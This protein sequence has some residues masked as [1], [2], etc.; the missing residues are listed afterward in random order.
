MKIRDSRL[1]KHVF[2]AATLVA[3]TL[4]LVPPA[5]SQSAVTIISPSKQSP[6]QT[7]LVSDIPGLAVTTDPNLI[8]P[9]GIS[10]SPTSPYWISDQGSGKATLY[11][12]AGDSYSSDCDRSGDWY[13]VGANRYRL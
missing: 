4:L 12:G 7:N 6:V 3:F 10:N 5:R 8:N 1:E 9:W 13:S 2:A 11:N